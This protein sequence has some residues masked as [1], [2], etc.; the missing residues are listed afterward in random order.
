MTSK[1]PEIDTQ[2][3]IDEEEIEVS[4]SVSNEEGEG[5]Y[6]IDMDDDENPI[7]RAFVIY[8]FFFTFVCTV[9]MF[10]C[11]TPCKA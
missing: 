8:T 4:G 11:E 1:H 7:D 10:F 6:Y 5:E 2:K 3:L 9:F